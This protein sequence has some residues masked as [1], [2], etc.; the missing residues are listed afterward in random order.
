MIREPSAFDV[1]SHSEALKSSGSSTPSSPSPS[2]TFSDIKKSIRYSIVEKFG[3][4]E[5]A[6]K[7]KEFLMIMNTYT[8]TLKSII[9]DTG[10]EE[11]QKA[12]LMGTTLFI[13]SVLSN[14]NNYRFFIG[15]SNQMNKG[16][17]I[18][19]NCAND[20][21]TP[22]FYYF[23]DG[24]KEEVFHTKPHQTNTTTTNTISHSTVS[25][26]N[27]NNPHPYA[28]PS[29]TDSIDITGLKSPNFDELTNT[30]DSFVG[31]ASSTGSIPIIDHHENM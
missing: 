9:E 10:D 3:Y 11:K 18:V 20:L 24:L 19:Q 6:L 22:E 4:H 16:M 17:V 31:S 8:S 7:K 13:Q 23:V 5:C 28:T 21:L 14:F 15:P 2:S 27:P 12:F 26:Q 25:S 29:P 30:S 1:S